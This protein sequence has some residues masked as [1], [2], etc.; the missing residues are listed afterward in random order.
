M[1][2]VARTLWFIEAHLGEMPGL[3]ALAANAGLS[4]SELSRLF[5][6]STGWT[7]RAY[8]RSRCLTEAARQLANGCSSILSVALDAGYGS[9]EAFTR[10]FRE[11]FGLTPDELRKRSHLNGL[12][13]CEALTM[14]P[15]THSRSTLADP[16]VEAE[17]AL[18]LA[19]LQS[20]IDMNQPSAFPALWQRFTP[21]IGTFGPLAAPGA[22]GAVLAATDASC[23]YLAGQRVTEHAELPADLSE[24]LV[25]AARWAK[26]RHRDHVAGIR[27]TIHAIFAD[28][29]P[30]HDASLAEG[31]NVIEYY[32]PD[33]DA[34]TGRGTIEIWVALAGAL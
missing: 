25:P 14:T 31:V 12:P 34:A 8:M 29:L 27:N 18:R 5:A 19:G 23:N 21:H 17:P 13:L 9:H 28:W 22:F 2:A 1:S 3:D 10:A 4:R 11:Q 16:R 20:D 7:I 24:V 26:F 15:A 33:F 32:G 6:I 30:A